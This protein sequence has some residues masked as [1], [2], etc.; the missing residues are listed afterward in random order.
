V[1]LAIAES[2]TAREKGAAIEDSVPQVSESHLNQ[3]VTMSA[4]FKKYIKA[5]HGGKEEGAYAFQLG[6]RAPT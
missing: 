3:V 5:T 1:A 4:A 6:N 2:Q